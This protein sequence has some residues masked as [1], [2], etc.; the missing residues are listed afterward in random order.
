MKN[1]VGYYV[2]IIVIVATFLTGCKKDKVPVVA[3]TAVLSITATTATSGG[4]IT[5]EG[6][7]SITSRGVCWSTGTTPTIADSKTTDGTGAGSF[8]SNIT[9]LNGA[10]I[11][12][13]RAYA[14]ND[15]GIG[16]GEIMP[17]TT[18]GQSPT[19][20]ISAATNINVTSATLNGS[21][22]ANYL[23]TVVTFD[24]GI[25]MNYDSTVTSTQS[26]LT[27]STT[28]NVSADI[29]GLSP[30]TTYHYRVKAVNSLGTSYSTDITFTTLGLVP[31]VTTLSATNMSITSATV[32]GTVNANYLSSV[33]TFEY[34]TTTSYGSTATATQSPVTGN[35]GTNVSA[36]II[37]L[38][39]G[40]TYHFRVKAVNSLGTTNGSDL[41]FTTLGQVPT[42]TT[43]AAT[44]ITSIA[45]QLNGSV[46]ANY[47]SSVVT[48]E[49]GT[50]TSYGS[51]ATATQSPVTGNTVTNVSSTITGLTAGTVYHF[52]VKAVNS[53]GTSNGSDITFTTFSLVTVTDFDGNIYNTITIGTQLWMAENLKT[54]NY[55]DGTA[56]PNVTDNTAWEHL[57]TGAYS[58]YNNTPANS[59]TYG[60]LYNWYAVDN[61]AAT[62][63][64]SNGG[65]NVCPTD[66]HVPTDA[67]WTTLTDYLGGVSIAGGKLKETGTTHWQNPNTGATNETGFTALPS[68]SRADHGT[69]Y[70]IEL[71]GYWW[72]S[73]Y[74]AFSL[75]PDAYYREVIYNSSLVSRD[76]LGVE[77]GY[78]VR[79]LRDF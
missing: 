14:S 29:M 19:P 61:N 45:A 76:Y 22:N 32:N 42:V 74:Y 23:S 6:S 21:V 44:G 79:C 13:V 69:Y 15:A 20:T 4:N 54:T 53:L 33:V 26:P 55:N 58:D 40:T 71:E 60:R 48:F 17:F 10:T 30:G 39:E 38:T 27:G 41:T 12:Y 36:D 5:D 70:D 49:Y 47:L 43:L 56:I 68:G 1:S 63:V 64:A 72:S 59:T 37:G 9:G 11:Y 18:L 50:T 34:G 31:T 25:T 75:W 52:R 77:Y 7:S 73:T 65:K 28:T 78:S 66:W 2:V 62:K 51:T 46:N 3:T 35:T 16:Y 8:S 24:Y 57:T 67:E